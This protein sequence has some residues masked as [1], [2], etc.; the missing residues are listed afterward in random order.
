MTERRIAPVETTFP[1]FLITARPEDSDAT[2]PDP[3][4]SPASS[5]SSTVRL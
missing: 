4:E 2:H 1:R 5:A 3:D